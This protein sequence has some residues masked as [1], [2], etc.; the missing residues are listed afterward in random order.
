VSPFAALGL[1]RLARAQA[2]HALGR[3]DDA[4]GWLGAL[5]QRSVFELVC[6]ARVRALIPP[7]ATGS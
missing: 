5:G 2:L 3:A 7:A 1:E 4:A 6:R